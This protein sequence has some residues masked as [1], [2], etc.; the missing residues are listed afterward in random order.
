MYEKIKKILRD[1]SSPI[2]GG[3]LLLV[4]GLLVIAFIPSK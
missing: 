3:L 2:F 4:I 1:P